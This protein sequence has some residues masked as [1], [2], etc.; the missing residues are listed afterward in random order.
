MFLTENKNIDIRKEALWV[1][2]NATTGVDN[3]GKRKILLNSNGKIIDV[4]VAAC[5]I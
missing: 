3:E 1:I 2:C 5:N 4:L